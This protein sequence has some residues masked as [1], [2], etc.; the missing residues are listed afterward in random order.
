MEIARI[1]QSPILMKKVIP[2]YL[3]LFLSLTA[4]TNPGTRLKGTYTILPESSL[5][6]HGTSNVRDFSC[7]CT[8]QWGSYPVVYESNDD[9]TCWYFDEVRLSIE[10]NSLDCHH[11]PI[12][13]D[14]AKTLQ[15][16]KYPFIH[17]QVLE[18]IQKD[19]CI[20]MPYGECMNTLIDL[21]IEIA[22]VQKVVELDVD[23]YHVQDETYQFSAFQNL[24]MCDFNI[25][26]PSA[27]LGLIQV[28][29]HIG[30]EIDLRI[31]LEYL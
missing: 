15:S 5:K 19:E 13:N 18:A 28:D 9:N 30:I 31:K 14:L 20:R 4:G 16:D 1:G 10:V 27:L 25:D 17:L 2:F 11:R 22:G 7:T 29:Q 24:D 21:N 12:T 8:Q 3:L 6:L 26:P 23:C